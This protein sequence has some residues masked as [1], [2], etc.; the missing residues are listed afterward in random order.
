MRECDLTIIIEY[1][2]AF[3]D[4]DKHFGILLSRIRHVSNSCPFPDVYQGADKILL[5]WRKKSK[6]EM[7]CILEFFLSRCFILTFSLENR[8]TSVIFSSL[9][10]ECCLNFF[11]EDSVQYW[12]VF[13]SENEYET[14]TGNCLMEIKQKCILKEIH[15]VGNRDSFSLK[16]YLKRKQKLHSY[17]SS[18]IKK[19]ELSDNIY[20]LQ[21]S[22]LLEFNEDEI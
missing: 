13:L 5:E 7:Y 9:P 22:S 20:S 1:T 10:P 2:E 19:Q 12:N 8:I 21:L 17:I 18:V 6:K 4:C 15:N 16:E 3:Q 14:E 11:I